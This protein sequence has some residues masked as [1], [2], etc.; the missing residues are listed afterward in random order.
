MGCPVSKNLCV[1]LLW[2]PAPV[3]LRKAQW[4]TSA[5]GLVKLWFL[6]CSCGLK[7]S[8]LFE[9]TVPLPV[10]VCVSDAIEI[11]Q[12]PASLSVHGVLRQLR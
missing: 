2:P 8:E 4:L 9:G 5:L 3:K 12:L 7:L 6:L 11:F 1:A 10:N